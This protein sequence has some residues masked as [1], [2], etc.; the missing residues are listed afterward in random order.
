[1]TEGAFNSFTKS[2]IRQKTRRWK[3]KYDVKKEARH[4]VKLQST[5]ILANGK[6]SEK[7]VYYS[8]CNGCGE[9]VPEATATVDHIKP[10]VNPKTGM[11]II[12]SGEHKGRVDWNPVIYGAFCE[13]DN[14]QVL[15]KT[16]HDAKTKEEKAIDT[17]RRRKERSE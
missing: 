2:M 1:M 9:I 4:P 11:I 6:R 14:L 17:E 5:T 12:K 10:I 3:P 15:C 13:A 7:L 16:C 8:L